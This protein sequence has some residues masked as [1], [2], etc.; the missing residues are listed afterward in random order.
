M[1]SGKSCDD[2]H[3]QWAD[4]RAK[5]WVPACGIPSGKSLLRRNGN[6]W[7]KMA[8]T[9]SSTVT[10]GRPLRRNGNFGAG[11]IHAE[12]A[13]S[14]LFHPR[15]QIRRSTQRRQ[16][17]IRANCAETATLPPF[18]HADLATQTYRD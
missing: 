11:V 16:P 9:V 7:R 13:T 2:P 18:F 17:H 8:L 6:L 10:K 12:A 14:S 3:D 4:D 15:Y 1:V 5:V